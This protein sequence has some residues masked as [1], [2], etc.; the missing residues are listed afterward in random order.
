MLAWAAKSQTRL[1]DF[2]FSVLTTGG[3]TMDQSE[4]KAQ[5]EKVSP[6]GWLQ[7]PTLS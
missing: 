3:L 1:S 5:A 7:P 4:S 2:H 6:W